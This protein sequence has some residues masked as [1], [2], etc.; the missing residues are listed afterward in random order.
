[1]TGLPSEIP[2]GLPDA[3][4]HL[5]HPFSPDGRDFPFPGAS[6]AI[7]CSAI[8]GD[9]D[10]LAT[11]SRRY[12][13]RIVPCFGI[14]PWHAGDVSCDLW[15]KLASLL[16]EFPHAGAGE[17]GLDKARFPR[18]P[19]SDQE[20]TFRKHLQLAREKN[21][22]V[23]LHCVRAWGSAISILQELRPPRLLVHAWHGPQENFRA[24]LELGAFFSVNRKHLQE[25]AFLPAI[26]DVPL[27]RIL[28]ETDGSP[29]ELI[30][31]FRLLCTQFKEWTP[32]HW[33]FHIRESYMN[34]CS[35]AIQLP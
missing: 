31:T 34:L 22:F 35:P 4:T 7:V 25:E 20:E 5:P 26:R 29:A 24:L 13:E 6:S 19:L 12:P 28:P 15:Q 32:E 10:D 1:M 33:L 3:H 11:L 27:E 16:D 14:H 17:T 2:P 21:R 8:P 18:I 30:P 23:T 9:W